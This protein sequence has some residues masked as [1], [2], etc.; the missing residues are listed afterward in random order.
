MNRTVRKGRTPH[1][2]NKLHIIEKFDLVPDG[3]PGH[4]VATLTLLAIALLPFSGSA[5]R[6]DVST[7]WK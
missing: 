7:A 1:R 3:F 5:G 6:V 4:E 2:S